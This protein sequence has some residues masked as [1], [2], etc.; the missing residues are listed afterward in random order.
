MRGGS[1]ASSR[2]RPSD[3][4]AGQADRLRA[5]WE[6]PEEFAHGRQ[7]RY[8]VAGEAFDW[9][10]LAERLLED[11]KGKVPTDEREALLFFGRPPRPLEDD[12]FRHAIGD[13]KHRAQAMRRPLGRLSGGSLE[14]R[15]HIGMEGERVRAGQRRQPALG[16]LDV[17]QRILARPAETEHRASLCV[18]WP[19]ARGLAIPRQYRASIGKTT[20]RGRGEM[21]AGIGVQVSSPRSSARLNTRV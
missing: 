5:V 1:P 3:Q 10:L 8:L 9:L 12:D 15:D 2:E 7:Y 11:C 13:V 4:R 19:L 18:R 6:A 16:C 20:A 14:L 17:R 21:F